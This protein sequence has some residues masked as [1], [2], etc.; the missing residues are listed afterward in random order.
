MIHRFGLYLVI[1]D[2]SA[3]YA[4]CTE[5]AV[6]HRLT[7]VQLRMK[8]Q[9]REE[10]IRVG[11]QMREITRGTSTNFIVNDDLEVARAV[12]AD[13][14]HL[15][16]DD[17]SIVEARRLWAGSQSKLFGLS[18]HNEAQARAAESVMPDYIGVGPLFA[19]PTKSIPDP[20]VGVERAAAIIRQSKLTCVAIGGIDRQRLPSILA[21]GIENFAVVRYVCGDPDP[22]AAI[23]RLREIWQ[24]QQP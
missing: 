12:D 3:G 15:G 13:G 4:A 2:P 17:L 5:A 19:T 6:Q 20:T 8:G 18:T 23:G 11:H 1:T 9:P 10:V 22:T 16:Q 24:G 21:A 14:L 7:Y